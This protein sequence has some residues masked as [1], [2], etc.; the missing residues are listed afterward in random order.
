M[1]VLTLTNLYPN[2]YQPNRATFNRHEVKE[3][4]CLH[5]V[6]VIAPVLWTDEMAA[7]LRGAPTLPRDRRVTCDGIPVEHPRYWY[8]PHMLRGS[9]GHC[10]L[11]S[12]R[13]AV[14]RA[15]RE[16]RPDV[17]Y[18]PWAYPDGWAAVQLGREAG[19]PVV[20]KVHGSDVLLLDQYAGRRRRTVEALRGADGV[21]AVSEDL[22]RNVVA[23]G[24]APWKARVIYG[25]VNPR[26]FCPGDRESARA[27][28]RLSDGAP[29]LLFVGNLVH[30]KGLDVLLEAC[31]L[32]RRQGLPFACRLVG[33]GPLRARLEGQILAKGLDGAVRFLGPLPH[34][35]LADWYRAA[36]AFVLPSRS[37]GVPNVL[38]E[39]IACGTPFVA[40]RVGGIPEV[41]GQGNG[42]LIPPEDAPALAAALGKALAGGRNVPAAPRACRTHADVAGDV[43]DFLQE[44]VRAREP[45]NPLYSI[46]VGV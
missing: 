2:S 14:R 42:Q 17:I 36:A 22:A 12:V 16:F 21:I 33:D 5:E 40:S 39:A 25:G 15:V 44:I 8:P 6:A 9:Y 46:P 10:F 18:T 3:L 45:N 24:A 43:A 35:Q 13:A 31:V 34:E 7:R 1:R 29:L 37:E 19:L 38:M 32:L 20:I 28:V 26:V 4:A 11:W 30:V 27:R 23:L 41:A